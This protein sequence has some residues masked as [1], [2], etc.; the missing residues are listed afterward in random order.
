MNRVLAPVVMPISRARS[1]AVVTTPSIKSLSDIHWLKLKSAPAKRCSMRLSSNLLIRT[2]RRPGDRSPATSP[3]RCKC[4]Q[5]RSC[6]RYPRR[7]L[8]ILARSAEEHC[9][10]VAGLHHPWMA[11]SCRIRRSISMSVVRLPH[12]ECLDGC[13]S[14]RREA[15]GHGLVTRGRLSVWLIG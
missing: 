13:R 10:M 1:P 12:T 7:N 11:I 4:G 8:W 6:A 9:S 15:A 14:R 3:P 5:S 2:K